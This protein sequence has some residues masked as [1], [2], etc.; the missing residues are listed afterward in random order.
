MDS[1]G[2]TFIWKSPSVHDVSYLG[3]H[4][5]LLSHILNWE[6]FLNMKGSQ[7][8]KQGRVLSR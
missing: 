1:D 7:I 5:P 2:P 4:P 6:N 8:L 3:D